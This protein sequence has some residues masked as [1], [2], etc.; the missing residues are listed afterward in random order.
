MLLYITDI[1]LAV[2]IT[3]PAKIWRPTVDTPLY[4]PC[5]VC[6]FLCSSVGVPLVGLRLLYFTC[7]GYAP[8]ATQHYYLLTK[9]HEI[10]D[11]GEY[12]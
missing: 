6:P 12:A 7:L 11:P 1:F 4:I 10:T 9:S 3:W 5:K 8:K 2:Q